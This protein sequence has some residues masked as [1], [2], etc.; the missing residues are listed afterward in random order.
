ME[1]T[2]KTGKFFGEALKGERAL[3]FRKIN[4]YIVK[5]CSITIENRFREIQGRKLLNTHYE[6]S[7]LSYWMKQWER[8]K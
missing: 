8:F 7:Q 6:R 5:L 1:T 4:G 2:E 3:I